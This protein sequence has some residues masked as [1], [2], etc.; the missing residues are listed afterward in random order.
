MVA[1]N[2]TW[3]DLMET[4]A[5]IVQ[6]CAIYLSVKGAIETKTDLTFPPDEE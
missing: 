5:D 1:L 3:D 6:R 4:P 2:W